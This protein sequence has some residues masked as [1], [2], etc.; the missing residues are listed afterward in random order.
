MRNAV[1]KLP[2]NVQQFLINHQAKVVAVDTIVGEHPE[3][4]EKHPPGHPDG[5]TWDNLDA[6]YLSSSNEVD[7]ANR[8]LVGTWQLTSRVEAALY[9]ELG[10]LIDS[11]SNYF[12]ENDK[13]YLDSYNQEVH[14]LSTSEADILNYFL[15]PPN[16]NANYEMFAELFAFQYGPVP[17]GSKTQRL[18]EERFAKTF[19]VVKNLTN[20]LH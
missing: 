15:S 17:S 12:S 10:H 14:S 8:V 13:T 2:A 9:H 5:Q 7:I 4:N 6:S 16:I 18:L 11:N 1:E 19:N 20:S 3:L